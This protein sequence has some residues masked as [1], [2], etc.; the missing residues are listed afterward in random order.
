MKTQLIS[1]ILAVISSQAAAAVIYID[2]ESLT[3]PFTFE[4]VYI[5]I[6]TG[7][8]SFNE[9]GTFNTAPWINLSEGG[10]VIANSELL[11]PWASSASYDAETDYFI[12]LSPGATIDS[13]GLFVS[14]ETA[15]EFHLGVAGNQ[16]QSGTQGNLAFEYTLMGGGVAY[17]WLSFTPNDNGEG[18]SF[19]MAY[20]DT[21]GEALM[22]GA[23]PEPATFAAI[24]GFIGLA[25]AV[26]RR[27]RG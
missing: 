16:F 2:L 18:M 12:N 21:P 24:A 8:T 20:S 10:A 15:S 14:G 5:N 3:I 1:T 19:A 17:G 26:S 13:S 4:G 11:R 6:L 22:V 9:P 25:F 27:R 7:D 23:I